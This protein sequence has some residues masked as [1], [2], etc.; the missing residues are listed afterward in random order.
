MC[1]NNNYKLKCQ[2][3]YDLPLIIEGCGKFAG[4]KHLATFLWPNYERIIR[5]KLTPYNDFLYNPICITVYIENAR[6]SM[7]VL[8]CNTTVE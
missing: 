6:Y 4:N 5:T 3:F 8:H 1:N 7:C 2:G